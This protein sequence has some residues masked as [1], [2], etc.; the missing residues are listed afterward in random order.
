[1]AVAA[2]YLPCLPRLPRSTAEEEVER[3]CKNERN[4]YFVLHVKKDTPKA[5]WGILSCFHC[6]IK[7]SRHHACGTCAGLAR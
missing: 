1:M 3:I 4:Y 5:R 7:S 6:N 2:G